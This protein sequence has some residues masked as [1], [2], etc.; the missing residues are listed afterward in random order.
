MD[1]PQPWLVTG[2]AGFIGAR[3]IE[4]LNE[5]GTPVVSVDDLGAFCSR[6]EHQGL[7]FGTQVDFRDLWSWLA[8]HPKLQFGAC[9]HL[10]ACSSTTELNVN[11]LRQVNVEY[12]QRIW[13]FCTERSVPL[14]YASSAATY[15]GGEQGYQD[16]ESKMTSLHPLNPYGESKRLFDVWALEEEKQGRHPPCWSGHKF[17]NVYGFGERHKGGQASV[18]L[19]AFDQ[20]QA[21]GKVRLFKSHKDTI[22]DGHQKRDFIFVGDVIDILMYSIQKPIGRG[23]YNVGTGQ[24]RTFL[25]LVRAVFLAT[26]TPEQI[27]FIDTPEAIRERYQYFTQATTERLRATGYSKPFTSLEEGVQRTV[28]QLEA[29][30]ARRRRN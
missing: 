11:F 9:I 28:A 6:P 26:Q 16:D 14:A 24:A 7:N 3:M 29:F 13:K 25:D 2:A 5:L 4:R 12:S 17:F 8:A 23:I 15:G 27:E 18:V 1:S 10:G 30:E 21:A 19:H 20:I 22:A